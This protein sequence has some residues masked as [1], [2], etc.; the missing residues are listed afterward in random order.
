MARHLIAG[1]ALV[2][3][4][5]ILRGLS[6]GF[7]MPVVGASSGHDT[8]PRALPVPLL[9]WALIAIYVWWS[10]RSGLRG[11]ASGGLLAFFVEAMFA[12]GEFWTLSDLGG[13]NRVQVLYVRTASLVLFSAAGG[14]AAIVVSRSP[15]Y[16]PLAVAVAAVSAWLL[17]RLDLVP[18]IAAL[19][20]AALGVR[21]RDI[22]WPTRVPVPSWTYPLAIFFFAF[23]LR[24]AL[25]LSVW[26]TI[27][28]DYPL[29]AMSGPQYDQR[30]LAIAT[31][32]P[33]SL[34]EQLVGFNGYVVLLGALYALIGRNFLAIGLLQALLGATLTLTSYVLARRLA[35][36]LVATLTAVLVAG[37]SLLIATA[38]DLG[39]EALGVPL[40]LAA[41]A[42]VSHARPR[43]L[44]PKGLPLAAGTGAVVGAAAVASPAAAGMIVVLGAWI[45]WC[46]RQAFAS[47]AMAAAASTAFSLAALFV[48]GV[49][50]MYRANY[51]GAGDFGQAF[52]Y[53]WAFVSP[54]S[55]RLGRVLTFGDLWELVL[56]RPGELL[57]AELVSL[58]FNADGLLFTA[59]FNRFDLFFL[60]ARSPFA[61][62]LEVY[63]LAAVL[64][65][66][67]VITV[68]RSFPLPER[69]LVL[70]VLLYMVV[71][72]VLVFSSFMA[73]RY[74]APY[75]ALF[76]LAAV[77]G[78]LWARAR[79]GGQQWPAALPRAEGLPEETDRRA[80][81]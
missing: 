1:A 46:A 15:F 77:C 45:W 32:T 17:S 39:R 11:L 44:T 22:P 63:F 6:I 79:A 5:A 9:F 59:V 80:A 2:F 34:D 64:L 69:V 67:V 42:L 10:S 31:A 53:A 54:W 16:A 28:S 75:D 78:V 72:N 25:A 8:P 61:A 66:F 51:P 81:S 19:G 48:L 30:A 27:G 29:H 76:L 33:M 37:D 26:R 23:G 65:G 38:A 71:I 56:T 68:S 60:A 7:W 52:H 57:T 74:R 73:T 50:A 20:G 4:Y 70:L 41:L 43:I 40:F 12:L 13:L 55:E 18:V 36:N 47:R 21:W 49:F 24:A 3:A 14:A 35:G 58:P 62:V